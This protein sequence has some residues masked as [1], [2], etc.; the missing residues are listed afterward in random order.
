M[1]SISFIGVSALLIALLPHLGF[2]RSWETWLLT[3]LGLA[4]V[5][6][7]VTLQLKAKRKADLSH[8]AESFV[9]NSGAKVV[10]AL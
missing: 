5:I 7:A 1:P 6:V 3:I 4:I 8:T 2:P 9:E 10:S